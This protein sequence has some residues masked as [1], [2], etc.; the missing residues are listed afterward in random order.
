MNAV[1][2]N[3]QILTEF[4]IL[5]GFGFRINPDFDPIPHSKEMRFQ[6]MTSYSSYSAS[7][8]DA[9]SAKILYSGPNW[10]VNFDIYRS[11]SE[12]VQDFIYILVPVRAGPRF[13]EIFGPGPSWSVIFRKY[14]VLVRLGPRFSEN[15][16]SWSGL[17]LDFSIFFGPGP[18]LS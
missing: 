17:V 5:N 8:I 3:S 6:Q 1:S 11:W 14:L 9:V 7:K 15:I 13:S 4:R 2:G 18:V 10:S 12:L 16:W